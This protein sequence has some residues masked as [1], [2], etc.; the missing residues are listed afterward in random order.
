MTPLKIT[1]K[2]IS[3]ALN[4]CWI[5]HKTTKQHTL[6]K[7]YMTFYTVQPNF[8]I[9]SG[10]ATMYVCVC[11]RMVFFSYMTPSQSSKSLSPD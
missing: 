9:F 3:K 4:F 5:K 7:T 11:V 2:D 6:P 8:Q 1:K 10:N